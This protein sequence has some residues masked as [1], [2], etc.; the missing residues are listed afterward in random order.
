MPGCAEPPPPQAK[1]AVRGLAT[2]A[3]ALALPAPA[4]TTRGVTVHL[5]E[6]FPGAETASFG[7][8]LPR[9]ALRSMS[10]LHVGVD[11]ARAKPLLYNYT[12]AGDVDSLRSVLVQIPASALRDGALD[13]HI[14]WDGPEAALPSDVA[15]YASEGVSASS[16]AVAEV[17]EWSIGRGPQGPT[18]SQGPAREERLFVGREPRV[19]ATFP[20]GYLASTGLFGPLLDV[21]KA[22]DQRFRGIAYLS[23]AFHAFSLSAMYEQGYP[24]NP[25]PESVIDPIKDYE[26]WLYDRCATFLI[27]YAHFNDPR[28]LRHGYKSCSYYEGNIRLEGE[29]AG[30]FAGKPEPDAKYSH[31]RGLYLDYALTGD[32]GARAAGLAIAKMW[33]TDP[34]FV[35]P[36]ANGHTRGADR[37]W[38]ERLLG[39][40]LEGLYYGFML[41]GD[42][43]YLTTFTDLFDTAYKHITGDAGVLATINPGV[44]F[45]PQNCFIHSAAQQ[46]EGG[47]TDPW[48]SPWMSALAVDALLGYQEQTGDGRVDE[49]FVRLGR[50]LRDSGTAYYTGDVLEDSFLKPSVCSGS[51]EDRRRLV[52]LYGVGIDGSG[53][54]HTYG[55]YSDFEHC[56]DATALTAAAL[57]ALRRTGLYDK[58]PVPPFSS[59]GESILAVHEELSECAARGFEQQTRQARDPRTW[60]SAR[61]AEGLG[62]PS[63]VQKNRIGFP[64]HVISPQ[65]KLSWWFNTSMLQ[66]GLLDEAKVSVPFLSAGRV[67]PPSCR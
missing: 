37:V 33:D 55:E 53:K 46:A 5:T 3:A 8:P 28:F 31:L 15:P 54:R 61:L 35:T 10:M 48:C 64:V 23:D 58:H 39:S 42:K 13:V 60:T 38:T 14:R 11:G 29:H 59:E 50:F 56:A 1:L 22:H 9:G 34:Y 63:F 17:A 26:G 25:D 52:P 32:E 2:K 40:S 21:K 7:V 51:G 44:A 47:A 30:I 62:D 6:T 18:L 24:L 66:Y 12:K 36:Y 45:P 16:A 67:Q 19:L 4:S 43:K 20:P 49:V 65:R 57:R 41:T 27:A